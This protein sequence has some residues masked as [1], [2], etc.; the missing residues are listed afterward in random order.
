[1]SWL[2]LNNAK[3]LLQNCNC[4]YFVEKSVKSMMSKKIEDV[5]WRHNQILH[6][7]GEQKV[8]GGLLPPLLG[9]VPA[10]VITPFA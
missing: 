4:C 5:L 3:Q 7:P 2:E 8:N 6:P 9:H 1:M 10:V